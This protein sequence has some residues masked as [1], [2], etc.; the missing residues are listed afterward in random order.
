MAFAGNASFPLVNSKTSTSQN[1]DEAMPRSSSAT[2]TTTYIDGQKPAEEN[3]YEPAQ[4]LQPTSDATG[5]AHGTNVDSTKESQMNALPASSSRSEK[6]NQ[7]QYLQQQQLAHQA[8]AKQLQNASHYPEP[9]GIISKGQAINEEDSPLTHHSDNPSTRSQ[10]SNATEIETQLPSASSIS[11]AITANTRVSISNLSEDYHTSVT[12]TAHSQHLGNNQLPPIE[13]QPYHGSF[14]SGGL[15]PDQRNRRQNSLHQLQSSTS[16]FGGF[17]SMTSP[18]NASSFF[19]TSSTN[20]YLANTNGPSS[21]SSSYK[22]INT[23]NAS[24]RT[25]FSPQGA[26]SSFSYNGSFQDRPLPNTGFSATAGS[27]QSN[28]GQFQSSLSS[29]VSPSSMRPATSPGSKPP[30]THHAPSISEHSFSSTS[31]TKQPTVRTSLLTSKLAAAAASG[32]ITSSSTQS[33]SL[34]GSAPTAGGPMSSS[35]SNQSSTSNFPYP[36]P[37]ASSLR[38]AQVSPRTQSGIYGSSPFSASSFGNHNASTSLGRHHSYG[39]NRNLQSFMPHPSSTAT[40]ISLGDVPGTSPSKSENQERIYE[41]EIQVNEMDTEDDHESEEEDSHMSNTPST[42]ANTVVKENSDPPPAHD[43]LGPNM[44][45][46]PD[47]IDIATFPVPDIIVMLTALLQKIIDA[48]DSLRPNNYANTVQPQPLDFA[49]TFTANVLAFHGRNIP[50]IA[51]QAYLIRILKYC[52]TTNEV[53]IALLVYFDRIA[54]R[55]NNGDFQYPGNGDP[56][57]RGGKQLFVMDSYNIHR[58]IIAGVTVGSKF[59][60]DVFYKNSR[61]AKVGGL[62]VDELNHLE[63]QF[64]LLTDFKLMI[65]IE[66]LQRYTDLLLGFWKKEQAQRV[67]ASLAENSS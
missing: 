4:P 13:P 59:F 21:V 9:I 14:Q 5:N 45:S 10:S 37:R 54:Q 3:I 34:S 12:P 11:G 8:Y 61:Y 40:N 25:P 29:N 27:L 7:Y 51:L 2:G 39:S 62:P 18:P 19:S 24:Y 16:S 42:T 53:F 38:K 22:S 49:N 48:N 57:H 15:L 52:P 26:S 67:Q 63:L 23:H 1:I 56:A 47:R 20:R 33:S 64:L 66:E 58:L 32:G 41:R 17:P 55:A 31:A 28:W 65:S 44:S 6:S 43:P 30:L 60:S 36:N 35:L 50:A 46:L